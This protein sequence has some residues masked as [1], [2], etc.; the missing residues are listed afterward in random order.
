MTSRRAFLGAA[1]AALAGATSP[2][3]VSDVKGE[4]VTVTHRGVTLLEY[5]YSKDRPK[6][7]VHPLCLPGGTPVSLDGPKDHIHHRGLMVA[8][9]EVN[10][11]DF[12]GEDNPARHGQIVHQ[13]FERL[14]ADPVAEIVAIN[15]WT[16]EGK[17]LLIER[18]TV[19]VPP[20]SREGTWLDW[21]TELRPPNEPVSLAAG[22]HV[23]NGLGIRVVPE[24]DGGAVLN[25]RGTNGIERANGEPARWCA[26]SGAGKTIA[27]FDHPSNPRHPNAF[28]VMNKAFGYM[29]AAP[30]FREP[31]QLAADQTIRFRWGVLAFSGAPDSRELDSRF[32]AWSRGE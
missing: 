14:T 31:F 26:Y 1:G 5:R 16:A 4:K 6:P 27:F 12:W 9:S 21:I 11:I 10:G 30:T 23:Y 28:F 7:Y 22:Q 32:D 29:S 2:L 3:R 8:W 15:H 13:R 20:A 17:S 18:R 24:M 25:S 19:R